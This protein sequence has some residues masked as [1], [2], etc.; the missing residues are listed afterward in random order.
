M[1]E[2]LA[3]SDLGVI[4]SLT[5]RLGE[6]MT[7]LTGE[8]GAGKTMI[9]EAIGLLLGSRSD[10]DRVRTGAEEAVV[11]GRFV[12]D[13]TEHVLRRV[14]PVTGRS[15][16]YLDGRLATAAELAE[17]GARCI[18]VHGQHSQQ[19]L[20]SRSSQRDALDRYGRIDL[21]PWEIARRRVEDLRTERAALGGDERTRAR[22][23]DLL[24]HQLEELDAAGIDDP[25]EDERLR[26]EEELLGDALGH[27]DALASAGA[28]VHDDGAAVDLVRGAAALLARRPPLSSTAGR[29]VSVAAELDDI[30]EELRRVAAGIEDDPERL[31]AVQQR[32][33]LLSSLRR[34]YG[35]TLEEVIAERE[36]LRAEHGRLLHA[37]ERAGVLDGEIEE[38]M[39][40]CE[41]A[42]REVG[43]ARRGAAT[44]LGEAVT[45]RLRPLG[46][47]GAVVE[48][49]V[50]SSDDGDPAGEN[51]ELLIGSDPAGERRPLAKVASGG[52]LSRTMLALHL[53]LSAGPPTMIFDEVDAGIG[54]ATAT[55]V[56]RALGGLA[57]DR[58]VIVVTHL[59]QVA[60]FADHQLAV[61]K[62]SR[63]GL[64]TSSVV[65]LDD[66]A[67]VIEL[68]R[69]MTGSP[70]S[71]AARRHA[72]ELLDAAGAER[73]R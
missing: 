58:Q 6:G 42:A 57:A 72:E 2:E 48:V 69:M 44:S 64:T 63:G 47:A 70:E 43:D 11:E 15:R 18:E 66:E 7:A 19:S 30:S 23:L 33:A 22:E 59:P 14:V 52:E 38:A 5:I 32:R 10:P 35:D 60:A 29:L 27:L 67:R 21:G 16:A 34:R 13:D 1:L 55:D 65:V 24:A 26:E 17:I 51:V 37:E 68:S 56:G 45:R 28:A 54:G 62:S 49:S 20:L 8:T 40:A 3:V 53:A 36:A 25:R 39:A 46:M 4:S 61:T 41:H 12:L 71:G 31:A 50:G 9:V 73:S